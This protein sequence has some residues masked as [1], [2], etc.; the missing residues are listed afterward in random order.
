MKPQHVRVGHLLVENGYREQEVSL[1]HVT[2]HVPQELVDERG[3]PDRQNS[4]PGAVQ[5]RGLESSVVRIFDP[6]Q[7]GN[8]CIY[9]A[10]PEEQRVK[11]FAEAFLSF[12]G[13]ETVFDD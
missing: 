6:G 2:V 5:M 12:Y 8:Q 3:F 11:D 10:S 9:V 1:Y 4:D 13:I 7:Y